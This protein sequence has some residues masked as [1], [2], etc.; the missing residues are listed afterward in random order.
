[1]IAVAVTSEENL[2]KLEENRAA[3]EAGDPRA[4]NSDDSEADKLVAQS[5]PFTTSPERFI[6]GNRR[7][8]SADGAGVSARRG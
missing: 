4:I 7:A 6:A 5:T 3:R 2:A 1:M 8:N